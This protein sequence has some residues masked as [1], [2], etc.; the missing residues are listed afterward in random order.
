M[1]VRDIKRAIVADSTSGIG[2][3]PPR[4]PSELGKSLALE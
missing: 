1:H 2:L 3:A 4:S